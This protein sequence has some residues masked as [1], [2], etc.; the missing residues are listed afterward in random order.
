[1]QSDVLERDTTGRAPAR[2]FRMPG[3]KRL[4]V[5]GAALALAL[6]A[7]WYGADWW[8]R[9]RFVE[10]TDDAYV[11]GDVTSLSPHVAGFVSAILVGDNEHV[12]A[13]QVVLRLDPRDCQAALERAQAVV[14]E[15]E[16]ALVRL[17]AQLVLQQ[18][19]IRQAAAD[20]DAKQARAVF[21]A[22]D[23]R[24]YADLVQTQAG[25]R[26]TAQRSFAADR[27]AQSAALAAKAALDAAQQQVG[28]LQ[29]D[30]AAARAAVAEARSNL[31]T[32]QLDLG[33]TEI[34]SPIDGYI[35]NRAVRVGGFVPA[36]AY[37]LSVVPERGLW[38]DANFKEDQLARMAPGQREDV[39]A[40]VAP[41]RVVHGRVLSLAPGTGAVFSVIPPENA[42]G[43][44]IKIVQRVPVRIAFEEPEARL[45]TL[46]PGLSTTVSVDTRTE[47]GRAP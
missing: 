31:Q 9:G 27:E 33:Y 40:D 46:R 7:G 37:L 14:A 29:A 45:G 35:A 39:V 38:V 47:T 2:T 32:A 18:S 21:T 26:Q 6:G 1:M 44:F 15:R 5:I 42:T 13:G 43:N 3:R 30:V 20:L 19:T 36:S 41:G 8:R 24:R 10:S 11:G 4:L 17:Q 25:S 34:R 22:E 12:R 28:V 16:A 23:A